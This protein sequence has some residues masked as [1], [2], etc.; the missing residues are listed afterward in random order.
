MIDLMLI[1]I[2][3]ICAAWILIKITSPDDIEK[4]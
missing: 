2:C 3:S 1:L 4:L